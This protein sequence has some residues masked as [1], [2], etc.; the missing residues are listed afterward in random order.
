MKKNA[1]NPILELKK[2]E[3][4]E[5]TL[6]LAKLA[7]E[8]EPTPFLREVSAAIEAAINLIDMGDAIT[9]VPKYK[10]ENYTNQHVGVKDSVF[11][12]NELIQ[13]QNIVHNHETHHH[14]VSAIAMSS[15][16][17]YSLPGGVYIST[18][19]N[20]V[21]NFRKGILSTAVGEHHLTDEQKNELKRVLVQDF[22]CR[23]FV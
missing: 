5:L 17:I 10:T 19:G 3:F 9:A 14:N 6:R 23:G 21:F 18:N 11:N 12:Q 7:E 22:N 1:N 8:E 15:D 20:F 2:N 16:H 13:E 4:A